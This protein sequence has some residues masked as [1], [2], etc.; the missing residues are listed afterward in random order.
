MSEH[1]VKE[2]GDLNKIIWQAN[3]HST[4]STMTRQWL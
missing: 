1:I 2:Y 4:E 3:N